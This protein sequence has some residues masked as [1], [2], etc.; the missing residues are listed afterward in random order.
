MDQELS[1]KI[2]P[3]P[4][5]VKLDAKDGTSE[6]MTYDDVQKIWCVRLKRG[7]EQE[8]IITLDCKEYRFMTVPPTRMG[9]DLF[10]D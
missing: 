10:D 5:K 9:D 7:I 6:L 2:T 4:D 3:K 1:F 8:V